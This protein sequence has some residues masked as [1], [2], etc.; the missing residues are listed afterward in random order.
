VHDDHAIPIRK[1]VTV[2]LET[3]LRGGSDDPRQHTCFACFARRHEQE[4]DPE[5]PEPEP[6]PEQE[7]DPE[8]PE[9]EPEPE[10][11]PE[12]EPEQEPDPEKPEPDPEPE[13]ELAELNRR[14][15]DALVAQAREHGEVLERPAREHE[16]R[17]AQAVSQAREVL[18]N[19]H[20]R[21]GE[22][23]VL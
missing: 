4:P 19:E 23:L 17:Q 8:E 10:P 2:S 6:E 14:H 5:E 9:P 22:L 3:R 20:N 15:D 12:P 21:R 7:P 13:P 1:G 16:L 18:M 11:K